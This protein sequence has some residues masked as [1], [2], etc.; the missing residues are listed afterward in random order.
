MSPSRY[1]A[2]GQ[3]THQFYTNG[4]ANHLENNTSKG[5]SLKN[6]FALSVDGVKFLGNQ[7]FVGSK[8]FG[9]CPWGL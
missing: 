8:F 9:V 7:S 4:L 5:Q 3:E 1:R 6:G 2:K